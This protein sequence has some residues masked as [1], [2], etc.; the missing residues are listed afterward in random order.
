MSSDA[1]PVS[2]FRLA[3]RNVGLGFAGGASFG[4]FFGAFASVF[5]NGPDMWV[6]IQE[7][8]LWFAVC[9]AFMGVGLTLNALNR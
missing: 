9:G 7:S 4:V 1:A 2:V 5:Y 8:W 6:G 3:L